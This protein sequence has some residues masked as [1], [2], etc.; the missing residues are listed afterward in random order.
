MADD[1]LFYG[2][3]L[4]EVLERQTQRMREAIE[5]YEANRL[6]NT[7]TDDLLT[8]FVAMGTVEAISLRDA[9]IAVDHRETKVDVSHRF[10]YAVRGDEPVHVPGAEISL[11]VPFDGEPEL[12]RCQPSPFTFNPPRG[13]VTAGELVLRFAGPRGDLDS[14]KNHLDS[15]LATVR[16]YV[17]WIRD[18]VRQHNDALAQ[19]ARQ[20]IE[21][22]KQL[23]LENQ[24]LVASLGY[25]L[26]KRADAPQTYAVPSVRR[27]AVPRPPAATSAPYVPEPALDDATYEQILTVLGNMVRVMEQSPGAFAGMN[28]EDLRT[29]F[30]VQLNG[31]FEGRATAETFRGSGS[32]DILL[33]ENDRSVFVAECKFWKGPASLIGALDQLLDYATWRDAK[34]AILVFNRGTDFSRVVAGASEA[35][36]RYPARATEVVGVSG[37]A[38]RFK[39]RQRD[40]Q[41]RLIV[42]TIL[43]YNVPTDR[44]TGARIRGRKKP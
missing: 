21:R 13:R 1:L 9:E 23:L 27:K 22:R 33:V 11:H 3:D 7:S 17:T 34:A 26:R 39:V 20:D 19:I 44:S 38:F 24:K 14:A 29:H 36:E 2:R 4:R 6:L 42:V 37:S 8:Y 10:D 31:Q 43:V 15:Q 40:D 25:P 16:Q 30:L 5:K 41:S 32:T 12:F 18:Q 35:L 28:E